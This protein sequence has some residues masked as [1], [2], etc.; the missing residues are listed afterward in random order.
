MKH[1]WTGAGGALL[2]VAAVAQDRPATAQGSHD[3]WRVPITVV[4][5]A[6]PGCAPALGSVRVQAPSRGFRM[7]PVDRIV[8]AGER[9]SDLFN[10]GMVVRLTATP[11]PNARFVGWSGACT[12][13][14]PQCRIAV[15]RPRFAAAN[16]CSDG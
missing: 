7:P 5:L 16:F 9:Y 6:G 11:G 10:P 2:L 1:R 3:R 8:A 4:A 12:H 15:D 14:G 13:D